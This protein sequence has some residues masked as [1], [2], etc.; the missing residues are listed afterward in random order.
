MK[1]ILLFISVLTLSS[2]YCQSAQIDINNINATVETKGVLFNKNASS[3]HGFEAL[4]GTGSHTIYATSLWMAGKDINNQIKAALGTYG[5]NTDSYITGPLTVNSSTANDST[6]AYG[7]ASITPS[8][9]QSYNDV[10]CVTASEI[11]EFVAFTQCTNDPDCNIDFP[12]YSIPSSILNWPAHGNVAANQDFYMAPFVDVDGDNLYNPMSG[13]YPCIKGDK[14]AWIITNDKNPNNLICDP[15][16]IEIHTEIYSYVADNSNPL[17]RTIFV[18]HDIINRSTQTMFDF[19]VGVVTDFDIGCSIDDYVGSFPEL[20][21]FF[22]YNGVSGDLNCSP[23]SYSGTPP[24]QS[25][26]FLN[27]NMSHSMA[28]NVGSGTY[29]DLPNTVEQYYNYLQAKFKDGTSLYYG[30]NGH[31]GSAGTTGATYD[32]HYPQNAPSGLSDWTE[33][34]NSNNPGERLMV[35]SVGPFLFTPGMMIDLDLA[36]VYSRAS[37]GNN[38]SSVLT[39]ENDIQE[40]QNYYDNLN[41]DC[42]SGFPVSVVDSKEILVNVY[43]NPFEDIINIKMQNVTE[44]TYYEI[45]D[46]FGKKITSGVMNQNL[47]LDINLGEI[48]Q[49]FYILSIKNDYNQNLFSQK[50]IKN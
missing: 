33:A 25:T 8:V 23:T 47:T 30:G 18:G 15:I 12:N 10:Y 1:Y 45:T 46:I 49:G 16:G 31:F 38:I 20:N 13:D 50:I 32:Y 9:S 3:D 28:I 6:Y 4:K 7:D 22:G 2:H 11:D 39:L 42:F 41:Q 19:Y 24:A 29:N 14:Y 17:S 43:P 44:N 26:T 48:P 40:V 37:N 27:A 35:G 21:S 36:Y 34:S 5:N